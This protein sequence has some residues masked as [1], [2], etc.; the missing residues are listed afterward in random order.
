M[1]CNGRTG[2]TF[3]SHHFPETDDNV[4]HVHEFW[5]MHTPYFWETVR[6]VQSVSGGQTPDSFVKF[7]SNV[8]DPPVE[9]EKRV[10]PRL[11]KFPY[12]LNML[13]DTIKLVQQNTEAKY[14]IHKNIHYSNVLGGWSQEDVV[15][16]SDIVIINYRKSILDC[17][18]SNVRARESQ[19]W[20]TETYNKKYDKRVFFDPARFVR[21]AKRYIS[22]YEA[23]KK[24]I[25]KHNKPHIVIEYE[26]FYKQPNSIDYLGNKLKSVGVEDINLIAPEMIKQAFPRDHYENN[27]T[28]P[29]TFIKSYPRIKKYTRYKFESS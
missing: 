25:K 19:I 29:E 28:K 24:A 21:F 2:S 3:L 1:M 6:K 22:E 26:T 14:F 7:L 9:G 17:W 12:T 13:T 15:K 11:A 5:S 18:I 4:F 16:I 23:I 27:F 20:V 8:Y 10:K